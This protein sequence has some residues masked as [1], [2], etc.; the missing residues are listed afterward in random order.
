MG[1]R[2]RINEIQGGREKDKTRD[3]V[4]QRDRRERERERDWRERE[5]KKMKRETV[6]GERKIEIG[7]E[8]RIRER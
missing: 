6:A 2:E 8:I 7:R 1:E 3:R 5:R 4:V